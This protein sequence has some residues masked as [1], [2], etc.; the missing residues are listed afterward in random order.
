MWAC[1]HFPSSRFGKILSS[2]QSRVY[3]YIKC[4]FHTPSKSIGTYLSISHVRKGCPGE[5][6]ELLEFK[7]NTDSL[8]ANSCQ[9][10]F[11]VSSLGSVL[12]WPFLSMPLNDYLDMYRS[13]S[14][15][16]LINL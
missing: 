3:I 8:Q 6:E 1:F 15:F 13:H 4:N 16:F 12:F 9:A 7:P 14:L 11:S 5:R 10:P 2:T